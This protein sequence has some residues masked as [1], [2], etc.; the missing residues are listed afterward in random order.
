[1]NIKANEKY[2]AWGKF[3]GIPKQFAMLKYCQVVHH[4]ANGGKSAYSKGGGDSDIMYEENESELDEDGCPVNDCGDDSVNCLGIRQST[5][6]GIEPGGGV[7]HD[8]TSELCLCHAS[9]QSNVI[10][11][12]KAIDEGADVN[13]ANESGHK[14][15]HFA[16]DRGNI[17]FIRI[18][19]QSG[20][21]VNAV[22]SDG[23]GV[24][25]TAVMGGN[26]HAVQLLLENGADP[27]VED[28]D[29]ETS[30]TWV[31]DDG[32]EEMINLFA[33]YSKPS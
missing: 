21:D 30:R 29:G 7:D 24:F 25:Q 28:V 31:T 12:Q 3:S 20:A 6:I 14:A 4:I 9:M 1:M 32:N 19:I 23:I 8:T 15:L 10:A 16:A 2:K 33:L 13:G 26:I 5:M 27:D 18:L 11:L 17:D 22:D